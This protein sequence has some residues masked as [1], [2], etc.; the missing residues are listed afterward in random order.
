[1]PGLAPGIHERTVSVFVDDRAEPGR[2]D[3]K[4]LFGNS[5]TNC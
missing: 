1:M 3:K 2:D 4:M 5:V